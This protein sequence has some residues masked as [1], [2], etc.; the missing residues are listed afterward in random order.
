MRFCF[1]SRLA[2]KGSRS[3]ERDPGH[4]VAW[5]ILALA[6]LSLTLTGCSATNPFIRDAKAP[7]P[8]TA[9]M[10]SS[11]RHELGKAELWALRCSQCHYARGADTFSPPQ[12]E[13]IMFHMRV[14]ANLTA[15]EHQGILEF[16]KA[17]N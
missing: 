10:E 5:M 8:T 17:S 4:W 6:T 7:S 15:E 14:R 13:L 2:S 3:G 1:N 12:W 16:L 9:E 11:G